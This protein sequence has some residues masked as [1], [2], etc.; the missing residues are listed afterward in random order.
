MKGCFDVTHFMNIF[1]ALPVLYKYIKYDY[2][3]WLF[4]G[5]LL[6]ERDTSVLMLRS[7][8]R[9][10]GMA[11]TS[12]LSR[13]ANRYLQEAGMADKNGLLVTKNVRNLC[14]N[15]SFS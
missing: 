9:S 7:K 8:S 14:H 1:Q 3:L 15:R 5:K 4:G 12:I 10:R 13:A 2:Y 6:S 11:I